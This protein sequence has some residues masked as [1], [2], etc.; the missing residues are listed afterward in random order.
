LARSSL[1]VILIA[2]CQLACGTLPL[3]L[4]Q[5]EDPGVV[6]HANHFYV[7]RHAKDKQDLAARLRKEFIAHG[8]SAESGPAA[9]MPASTEVIVRY[10]DRWLWSLTGM[11]L[12][13]MMVMLYE[14]GSEELIVA[15]RADSVGTK[16]ALER[17]VKG[18]VDAI[19]ELVPREASPPDVED[20][21]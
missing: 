15:G 13:S 8:V 1:I 20:L 5:A 4:A 19:F 11:Y 10:S 6:R 21:R 17:I 14:V 12:A 3:K 18:A 7:E 16:I 9:A 2:L